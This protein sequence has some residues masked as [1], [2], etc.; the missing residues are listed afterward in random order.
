MPT[1]AQYDDEAT[2]C[3]A[4]SLLGYARQVHAVCGAQCMYC[5]MGP[6]NVSNPE[7]QFDLWRQMEV[8]HIVPQ[9][10]W[11][12]ERLIEETLQ[13][14]LTCTPQESKDLRERVQRMNWV[15]A[16]HLCNS[17]AS[18]YPSRQDET[19]VK[20]FWS[21]LLGFTP[22]VNY[23]RYGRF[24]ILWNAAGAI[25]PL[26][27]APTLPEDFITSV[28]LAII[29]VWKDK[30]SPVR[31]K[32]SWLRKEYRCFATEAG[33]LALPKSPREYESPDSLDERVKAIIREERVR[34]KEKNSKA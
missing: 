21:I 23:G 20:T 12:N 3:E 2:K 1:W 22:H 18:R 25:S 10:R 7:G 31:K 4:A 17:I 28:G 30:N 24:E 9:S 19:A 14:R 8:E 16:C 32:T 11:P 34:K 27:P 6:K 33:L 29:E 15:T 5:G 26:P 13:K